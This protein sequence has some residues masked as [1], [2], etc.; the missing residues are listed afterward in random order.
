MLRHSHT[1]HS[2]EETMLGSVDDNH[3]EVAEWLRVNLTPS[4][5]QKE[6]F[7]DC[8]PR[9]AVPL[10]TVEDAQFREY[11]ETIKNLN[12]TERAKL[13][14]RLLQMDVNGI[15]HGADVSGFAI[16]LLSFL[17]AISHGYGLH[18]YAANLLQYK[19]ME[20]QSF[21]NPGSINEDIDCDIVRGL[22]HRSIEGY[23]IPILR[24][25]DA[26]HRR[27]HGIDTETMRKLGRHLLSLQSFIPLDCNGRVIDGEYEYPDE[28]ND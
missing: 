22:L 24:L 18:G 11:V 19:I 21:R 10:E 14:R 16:D 1:V 26:G 3:K 17:S 9:D 8:L 6:Y 7:D 23:P 12:A 4:L 5:C 25:D 27:M 13:L 2:D 15:S 20:L 28:E